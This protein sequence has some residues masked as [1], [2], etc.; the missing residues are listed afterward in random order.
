[1]VLEHPDGDVNDLFVDQRLLTA[2][3]AA[4]EVFLRRWPEGDVDPFP[5]LG[6][7]RVVVHIDLV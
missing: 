1:M 6:L 2:N 3:R 7:F 5:G 4:I